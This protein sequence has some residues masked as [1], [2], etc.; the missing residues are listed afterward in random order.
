M[1]IQHHLKNQQK[2]FQLQQIKLN[3]LKQ[4]ID[5]KPNPISVMD[6]VSQGFND[7]SKE[8]SFTSYITS[9]AQVM[10]DVSCLDLQKI[11]WQKASNKE[12]MA[13]EYRLHDKL[14]F[15]QEESVQA[16]FIVTKTLCTKDQLIAPKLYFNEQGFDLISAPDINIE[17][18]IKSGSIKTSQGISQKTSIHFGLLMP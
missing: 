11:Y 18:Q 14:V 4:K 8:V 10:S 6:T 16:G 1:K 9:V 13:F 17:Q 7:L 3:Y 12:G 5:N 15:D 2:V